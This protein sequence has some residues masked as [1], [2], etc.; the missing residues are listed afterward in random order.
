MTVAL[1]R[2]GSTAKVLAEC[3]LK[4]YKISECV[5]LGMQASSIGRSPQPM[6]TLQSMCDLAFHP[7]LTLLNAPIRWAILQLTPAHGSACSY[8]T[9]DVGIKARFAKSMTA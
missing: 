5:G 9:A 3:K 8:Q 4:Y 2:F 7:L 1:L 6:L